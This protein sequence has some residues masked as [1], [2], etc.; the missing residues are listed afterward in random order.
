[1]KKF[2]VF[3]LTAALA[4][5]C[6]KL[7]ENEY[8]ISG[9]IDPAFNGKQVFL[10]EQSE[11]PMSPMTALDTAVVENGKFTFK[12]ISETPK[13]RLIFIEGKDQD[14]AVFVYTEE[15]H[16]AVE[17]NKDTLFNS[18]VSGTLNND[19][20]AKYTKL[21]MEAGR[22]DKAFQEKNMELFNKAKAENDTVTQNKII[23]DYQNMSK[24][25][26]KKYVAF[27]EENP[28]ALVTIKAFPP[29]FQDQDKKSADIQAL[30]DKLSP[31]VKETELGKKIGEHLT[32]MAEVEAAQAKVAE[33]TMAPDFSAATPDGK[34]LSL[35]E[36]MGKVTIIDFWAS[37][38]GPCRQEN[39]NVVAMYNELHGKGLNIIG[40]SLDQDAAKWKDAI[41]A[42][43]LTWQHI[44]H[45]KGWEDPIA[46][47]YGVNGIPATFI[48]DASGKIVAKN[49]RGEELKAKVKEL[50]AQ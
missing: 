31:E 33:G 13:E 7:K 34:T 11:N 5:S 25:N 44:S 39:P 40:V 6:N 42:D 27:I 36:A 15:G 26:N 28:N 32:K 37:W 19:A 38:C 23:K 22:G 12:G 29:L 24:E 14:G 35:K 18:V 49:L 48:L 8:E 10:K 17:V 47:E 21:A 1:M 3:A 50:L 45:L 2:L 16:I 30:Y 20:Q 41:A 9:T 4:V 43:K 46:K